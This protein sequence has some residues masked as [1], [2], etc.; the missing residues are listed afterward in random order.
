METPVFFL[1]SKANDDFIPTTSEKNRL[2]RCGFAIKCRQCYPKRRTTSCKTSSNSRATHWV[3]AS[4]ITGTGRGS[5]HSL[6]RLDAVFSDTQ[7]VTVRRDH[8]FGDLM[9]LDPGVLQHRLGD[10]FA[11]ESG[12]DAGGLTKDLFSTFWEQ[13]C[14]RLFTSEDVL[15]PHLP[16]HRFS[17]A[18]SIYPV[19]GRILCH[20]LALT[21]GFPLQIC[22]TVLI[23]TA[24]GQIAEDKKIILEDF[25]LFVSEHERALTR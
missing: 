10:T 4:T 22:R 15:V 14:S 18:S 21:K 12:E 6:A 2:Q 16:P 9:D 23:S 5:F 7:Q 19:L 1:M 3:T 24:L 13:A 8:V 11:G 20:G 25:L 17:Q